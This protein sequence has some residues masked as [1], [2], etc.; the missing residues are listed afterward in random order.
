M[1]SHCSHFLLIRNRVC[2]Q[3][4]VFWNSNRH[5][6]FS[7]TFHLHCYEVPIRL[8]SSF[9][10]VSQPPFLLEAAYQA[11]PL[12]PSAFLIIPEFFLALVRFLFFSS[13]LRQLSDWWAM[14]L[15][16]SVPFAIPSAFPDSFQ[17]LSAFR[18]IVLLFW[19]VR[20]LKFIFWVISISV[21]PLFYFLHF[22]AVIWFLIFLIIP[23][24]S[25]I[26]IST[27]QYL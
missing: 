14:I 17:I 6:S 15:F 2:F 10:W 8:C 27:E 26:Q 22:L 25:S 12:L 16:S 1:Q 3:L 24:S 4:A 11:W 20:F 18:C 5:Q 9:W 19:C 7:L 13:P 21:P 23:L